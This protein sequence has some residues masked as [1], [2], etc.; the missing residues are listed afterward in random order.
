MA[1]N[2]AE[3][4]AAA[5]LNPKARADTVFVI[6]GAD[7]YQQAMPSATRIELTEVHQSPDG[8]TRFPP[9]DMDRWQE[10][11]REAHA[12]DGDTPAHDF[13]TLERR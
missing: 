4:V 8:D 1:A 3:A 10:V 2:L 7:I 5:G 12:A 6:G 11:A 9:I 13:V